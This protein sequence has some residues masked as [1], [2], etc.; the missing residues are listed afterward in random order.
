MFTVVGTKFHPS[1]TGGFIDDIALFRFDADGHLDANFGPGGEVIIPNPL[2][3]QAVSDGYAV[4]VMGV[5]AGSA[6]S[7][8]VYTRAYT[9]STQQTL[10]LSVTRIQS[11][12]DVDL[13]FGVNG[14]APADLVPP[15]QWVAEPPFLSFTPG[16]DDFQASGNPD[17]GGHVFDPTMAAISPVGGVQFFPLFPGPV[18]TATA[19]VNG[20]G[21]P[22]LV[23][24]A[25]P[26]GGPH[27]IVIDGKTH[28]RMAELFAFEKAYR[29]GVFVAAGDINC[30][31]KADVVVT[32][33]RSGGPVVVVYDGAKLTAGYN[34]DAQIARFYGIED[35]DFRGGA[36]PAVGDVNGDGKADLLISA[37]FLG[38]PREAL[39]DGAGLVPAGAPPK[40][41]ADFYAFEDSLRNGTYVALGDLTGDGKADLIFGGGPS[42]GPRVRV[43]DGAKLLAAGP[44]QTLDDIPQAQ[45]ANFFASDETSRGGIRPA[46]GTVNGTKALLTGSGEHNPAQIRVFTAPTLFGSAAPSPDQVLDVFG[47]AAL[48]DGVFV[49]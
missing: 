29:N 8:L 44:F 18:R 14:S 40:L 39:Y 3:A 34:E 49:G 38:G 42:G 47:G 16:S 31:G 23:G 19:D 28:L 45:A 46:V 15:G 20:D 12:G 13:S 10:A 25:G 27:V 4:G 7:I 30:D 24:G 35:P 5:E 48:A 6:G 22:D 43:M 17:G 33:D 2:A 36:R 1:D 41:V 32:P 11:S 26:D 37:G 9:I 21:T